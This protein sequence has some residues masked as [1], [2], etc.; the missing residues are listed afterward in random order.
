MRS[1]ASTA[2]ADRAEHLLDLGFLAIDR[3][4]GAEQRP[5]IGLPMP[6]D[7]SAVPSEFVPGA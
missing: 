2:P 7:G 6:D 4:A 5:L 3:G 1:A